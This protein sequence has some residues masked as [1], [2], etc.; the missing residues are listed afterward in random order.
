MSVISE[1][2]ISA[3]KPYWWRGCQTG[4]VTDKERVHLAGSDNT[5]TTH[6]NKTCRS[7]ADC[8]EHRLTHLTAG[9]T[10]V[11]QANHCTCTPRYTPWLITIYT[12]QRGQSLH[13]YTAV[14][15][16]TNHYTCMHTHTHAQLSR[17]TEL[18]CDCWDAASVLT[19]TTDGNKLLKLTSLFL[20]PS[21]VL[22]TWYSQ[23]SSMAGVNK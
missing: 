14:H 13:L 18:K 17:W 21:S 23:L 6:G 7:T 8:N 1:A 4:Y 16:L 10:T 19:S 2:S 11:H 20:H 22:Y 3:T 9:W 15:T 5:T 12:S